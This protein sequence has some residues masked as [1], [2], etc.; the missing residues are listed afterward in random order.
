[1]AEQ[2]ELGTLIAKIAVDV[3]D[4]KKGLQ[5]G[6]SELSSFK[7]MATQVGDSVK[8]ALA[9]AGIGIG[10][11]EITSRLKDLGREIIQTGSRTEALRLSTYVLASNL[12]M[13]GDTVEYYVSQLKQV[14]LTTEQSYYA[15]QSFLKSGLS[16][17]KIAPFIKALKDIAPTIRETGGQFA[18]AF[19]SIM[20]ALSSGLP[21]GIAHLEIPGMQQ[22][23]TALMKQGDESVMTVTQRA[24]AMYDFLMS[25]SKQLEGVAK[26]TGDSYI[27]EMG[28][29]RRAGEEA[30]ESLFEFLKPIAMAVAGEQIKTWDDIYE[31]VGRN[32]QAFRDAGETVGVWIGKIAGWIRTIT[33]FGAAHKELVGI[34]L[35]VW[36]V[37][38]LLGKF[39]IAEGA[40][41][42]AL[43]IG[44][45]TGK[46]A[47]LRLM[48]SSPWTL[49]IIV[50]LLGLNEAR[51]AINDIVKAKPSVG[52]SMLMGEA[53]GVLTDSQKAEL[54]SQNKAADEKAAIAGLKATHT[55]KGEVS[56]FGGFVK[57]SASQAQI[58]QETKRASEDQQKRLKDL[59]GDVSKGGGKG[60]KET[61]IMADYYRMMDQKRQADIQDAQTSFDIF[62]AG[63]DKKKAELE[64]ALAAGEIDGQA[65]YAALA[66]MDQAEVAQAV[67]LIEVKKAAQI[68]AR[69]DAL[70][71]LA[72]QKDLAPEQIDWRTQ[73]IEAAHRMQMKQL[74]G[75]ITKTKLEGEKKVTE[76]LTKQEK[77]QK[78]IQKDV[79]QLEEGAAFGPI[80][81]Q[82]AKIR[83]LIREWQDTR[84]KAIQ[85]G[86]KDLLPR[87]DAAYQKKIEDAKFGEDIRGITQSITSGLTGL[88]DGLMSG[89]QDLVKSLNGFFKDLFKS[90]L[91]PGIKQLTQ[92]LMNA[93]KELFGSLGSGFAAGIMG[94]IGLV[95]MIFT[96]GGAKSSFTPA[97][98]Q[99]AVTGHEAVR[100]IIGGATSIPI[101]QIGESLQDALVPTNGILS[102]IEENT[103]G[104]KGFAVTLN[105]PGLEESL[106]K[107]FQEYLDNFFATQLQLGIPG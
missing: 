14:G 107:L 76:E 43:A 18:P 41:T 61:D 19:D 87:I 32:K 7:G 38:K 47:A 15:I 3:A 102:Q 9:F 23:L 31:A 2:E 90:A 30:K 99:S 40:A 42:A 74:D 36:G 4:L 104:L 78:D 21:R 10:I 86:Q 68:K 81:E 80:E 93:F 54:A 27:A 24:T 103:R 84:D 29:L 96:G 39:A 95:G 67:A 100:G 46:L 26:Q 49:A 59:L 13:S 66:A 83:G 85:A 8:K 69:R 22:F 64:K 106:G 5:E 6:R 1:M 12:K 105:I 75:E 48:I 51:K 63:Q 57:G 58:D 34:I 20:R 94:V 98:V 37:S 91:E 45:L 71:D 11:Y 89:G 65:Y 77:L 82:E 25:Y 72:G 50:S 101:A 88:I 35:S 16:V 97:G 73:A 28:R 56:P 92:W 70:A 17:D 33:E 53:E 79:A 55:G 52:T 62:K 44:G 60:G